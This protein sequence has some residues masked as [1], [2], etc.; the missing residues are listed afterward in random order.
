MALDGE[1]VVDWGGG[2]EVVGVLGGGF[3]F[4]NERVTGE[5]VGVQVSSEHYLLGWRR[6]LSVFT[7]E[8]E[9]G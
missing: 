7:A 6:A 9:E 2:I 5:R 4:G 1:R 8:E 3:F